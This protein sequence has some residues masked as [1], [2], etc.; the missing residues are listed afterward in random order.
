MT[1]SRKVNTHLLNLKKILTYDKFIHFK[2]FNIYFIIVFVIV[3]LIYIIINV[4]IIFILIT[5]L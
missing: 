2:F 1:K 5:P 3:D 4:N